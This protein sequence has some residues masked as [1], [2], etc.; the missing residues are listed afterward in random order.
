MSKLKIVLATLFLILAA[1][2]SWSQDTTQKKPE[3][4]KGGSSSTMVYSVLV[5]VIVTDKNGRH[6]NDLR[7]KEF[8]V[9]E[10]GVKQKIDSVELQTADVAQVIKAPAGNVQ[11]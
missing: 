5:D 9:Y 8:E 10:N 1:S 11:P 7:P 3:A 6:V 4:V 2:H